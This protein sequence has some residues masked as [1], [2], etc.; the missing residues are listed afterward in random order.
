MMLYM[1][2]IV[3]M[4]VSL[5]T[6]RIVLGALGEEDYGIYTLV[7][8][9]VGMMGM[10][11]SLL[12]Q[13]TSRFLTVA[14]G[15]N[16]KRQLCNTFSAAITIHLV[17]ALLILLVGEGVGP[18]VISKLNIASDRMDAAQFVFQ[19]SLISSVVTVVQIPFHAVIVAHEKMNVYAYISIFEVVAKLLLVCLL[20]V[21]NTDKLKLYATFYFAVGLVTALLYYLYGRRHFVEC[22]VF[23]LHPD[24][25]L[26]KEMADYTGW[27]AIGACAFTM[28]GQGVTIL[29]SM[30]GTVVNAARGLAGYISGVVYNFVNNFQ[31]A[32]RPQIVKL[33]AAQDYERMNKLVIKVSKF[34]AYLVGLIGVPLFLEM[35]YVLGMWL[36]EVPEYTVVFAR[37]TL[38]QGFVQAMDAPI[39]TGI[40][41]VGRMRLPNLTSA[42]IYMMVLPVSY[43]AVKLGSSPEIA[44]VI[45]VCTYPLALCMDLYILHKYTCFPC[46]RF[47]KEAIGLPILF[48]VATAGI[49]ELVVA[50]RMEDSLGRVVLTTALSLSLFFG[51]ICWKGLTKG[52]RNYL[53]EQITNK[54]KIYHG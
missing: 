15:K 44:Y 9:V 47:F 26:Y 31:T 20:L 4:A 33:C 41:A 35:D 30:F 39:G 28:N 53:K 37:L 2:M 48:V 54:L 43:V 3:G 50:G 8:S 42:F 25:K 16:D 40:H 19:L 17:L 18:G 7:G 46:V 27:N 21:V 11:T 1:R 24:W 12:S 38:L 13:G 32:A 5:Y 14:L 34:S 52:E 10:V 49:T 45:T 23:T 51:G 29:L 36:Y 6:T 22:R